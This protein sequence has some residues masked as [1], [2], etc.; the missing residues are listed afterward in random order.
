MIVRLPKK[1]VDTKVGTPTEGTHAAYSGTGDN[2]D[3]TATRS[4][5]V[6]ATGATLS[7]DAWYDMEQDWDYTFVEVSTDNGTSWNDV[8]TSV[9]DDAANDQSGFN[10]DGTGIS[11]TSGAGRL[12]DWYTGRPDPTW[13]NVTANLSAY[14]GKTV[15]LRFEYVS[16]GASHGLGFEFDNL[17]L[18]TLTDG[19][20]TATDWTFDGGFHLTTGTDTDLF[21][22]YYVLENRQ[23]V[24]YDTGLMTAPYNF[25]DP[26]RPNWVERYP[27]DDGVLVSYWDTSQGDNNTGEHPGEGL[28]LPIDVH[29]TI[30]RKDDGTPARNRIQAYDA[31]LNTTPTRSFYLHNAAT[32]GTYRVRSEPGIRTFDDRNSFWNTTIPDEGVKTPGVGVVVDLKNISSQGVAQ[33]SVSAAKNAPAQQAAANGSHGR[34]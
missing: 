8:K 3:S 11:G 21:D 24:G 7:F 26:N 12:D 16:D 10:S 1:K 28:I 27:F 4:V 18:G 32:G 17:K 19:L 29:Q 34:H 15:L 33:I 2:F 22:N 14:A 30:I 23:Y 20:E 5:A 31:T 25:F 6:P 13:V 9:S